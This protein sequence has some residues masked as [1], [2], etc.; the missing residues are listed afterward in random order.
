MH[1][2]CFADDFCQP[3]YEEWFAEAVAGILFRSLS[4]EELSILVRLVKLFSVSAITLSCTQTLSACLTALGRPGRAAVSM[5]IAMLT[6][7]MLNV[8]LVKNPAFSIYGAAFAASGGYLIS[9]GLDFLF[10][11]RATRRKARKK[12]TQRNKAKAV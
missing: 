12:P 1:R 6:K 5:A 2:D 10:A 4:S 3:I 8:I 11:M 7:T 9:F